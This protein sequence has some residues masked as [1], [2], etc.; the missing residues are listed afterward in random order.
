MPPSSLRAGYLDYLHGEAT[1]QLDQAFR[2]EDMPEGL[3]YRTALRDAI[4]TYCTLFDRAAELVARF[5]ETLPYEGSFRHQDALLALIILQETRT[6]L[7]ELLAHDAELRGSVVGEVRTDGRTDNEIRTG[8]REFDEYH[9]IDEKRR[10][11]QEQVRKDAERDA[12][13]RSSFYSGANADRVDESVHQSSRDV[14]GGPRKVSVYSFDKPAEGDGESPAHEV[15][16]SP[17][18]SSPSDTATSS[19]EG[20]QPQEGLPKPSQ[21]ESAA[22]RFFGERPRFIE[23]DVPDFKGEDPIIVFRQA[24]QW[25]VEQIIAVASGSHQRDSF[26]R[27]APIIDLEGE[28]HTTTVDALRAVAEDIRGKV[29]RLRPPMGDGLDQLH[30]LMDHMRTIDPNDQRGLYEILGEMDQI[31]GSKKRDDPPWEKPWEEG[32]WREGSGE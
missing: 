23:I 1:D 11:E 5:V 21:G 13:I 27:I 29:K 3:A 10:I 16:P 2:G 32:G 25:L 20:A 15:E 17:P 28:K 24:S 4:N 6:A 8:S 9:E 31:F 12:D 30:D 19:S 7:D 22:M 14:L 18:P 26:P